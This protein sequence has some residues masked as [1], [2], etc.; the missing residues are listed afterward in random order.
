MITRRFTT[1]IALLLSLCS[2]LFAQAPATTSVAVAS[3]SISPVRIFP[4]DGSY[5]Y[6]GCYNETT[7]VAGSGGERA[8]N[9]GSMVE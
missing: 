7:G 3:A 6:A 4:G 9:G 2:T 8:L 1:L 5:T